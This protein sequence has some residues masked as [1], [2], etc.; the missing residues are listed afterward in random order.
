MPKPKEKF[1]L[2]SVVTPGSAHLWMIAAASVES[3]QELAITRLTDAEKDERSEIDVALLGVLD[4]PHRNT[5]SRRIHQTAGQQF[6]QVVD[7]ALQPFPE[8]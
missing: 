7:A 4:E 2:I 8:L 3:A 1:F 5:V 6:R